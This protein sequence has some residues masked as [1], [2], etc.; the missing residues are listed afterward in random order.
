MNGYSVDEGLQRFIYDV[1][2]WLS[3]TSFLAGVVFFLYYAGRFA[4]L[5]GAWL[6]WK[7]KEP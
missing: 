3:I 4:L 7:I 6:F 2:T 1:L 5:L